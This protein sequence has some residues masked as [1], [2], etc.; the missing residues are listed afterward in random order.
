MTSGLVVAER[1]AECGGRFRSRSRDD[2]QAVLCRIDFEHDA[3]RAA[4]MSTSCARR[5][6]A[7]RKSGASAIDEETASCGL[8]ERP[9][10]SFRRISWSFLSSW[11][12]SRRFALDPPNSP[13][14]DFSGSGCGDSNRFRVLR[15]VSIEATTIRA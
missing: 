4:V 3:C 8:R 14:P 6:E 12:W 10:K 2:N 15:Y 5:C 7:P 1:D 11:A 13:A 9:S